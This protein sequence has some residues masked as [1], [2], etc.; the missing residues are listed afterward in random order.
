MWMPGWRQG[1]DDRC[2]HRGVYGQMPGMLAVL[3]VL[4]VNA[5]AWGASEPKY[6]GVLNATQSD[7]PPSLSIHEEATVASIWPMMPCYNN[8]VL[9]D[10]LKQRENVD[11]LI[12]ELAE[13]WVWQDGGRTLAFSLR[14]GVKWHDGQPFSSKDV[15]FTFDVLREAPGAPAKLR[16][17]PRKLWY[18]NV[19]DIDTPNA[20]TVM[21][22]LTRPQPSL[23]LMLAAG[24]SPIY[25]AHVPPAELRTK[26]LGTGPF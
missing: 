11:T 13:R 1:N 6:G 10:P 4:L 17:N 15:K 8:L 18:E 16:V 7:L 24:Y 26:C 21:F 5:T 20:D 25:P 2:A 3:I 23:L 14:K 9:F 22:R 19:A 12:G